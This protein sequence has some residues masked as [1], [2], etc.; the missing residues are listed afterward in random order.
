VGGADGFILVNLDSG[1]G[2]NDYWF[3]VTNTSAGA[4]NDTATVHFDPPGSTPPPVPTP[5]AVNPYAVDGYLPVGQYANRGGWGSI[6]FDGTNTLGYKPYSAYEA[7][8]KGIGGYDIDG[9][10]LGAGGGYV[11]YE[12]TGEGITNDPDNAYGVDFIVYGNAIPGPDNAEAG[13]VKV[14]T[15][16]AIWYELAGSRYYDD[17]TQRHVD[18]SYRPK[19]PT[20][21]EYSL[22]PSGSTPFHP[23]DTF[24]TTKPALTWWPDY[25]GYIQASGAYTLTEYA[26]AQVNNVTYPSTNSIVTYSDVALVTGSNDKS[27]FQFGYADV[28]VSGSDYGG[29]VNPYSITPMD[30]GGDGFDIS[31]AISGN[32][33]PVALDYVKYIRIYT[34]AALDPT[35]NTLFRLMEPGP[36]GSGEISTEVCGVFSTANEGSGATTTPSSVSFS[37]TTYNPTPVSATQG[38]TSI[39]QSYP[40]LTY[41]I[42]NT[43]SNTFVNG[44]PLSGSTI[45]VLLPTPGSVR[46]Y[47]II[48][49]DSDSNAYVNTVK[50]TRP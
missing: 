23:W 45:T 35:D 9:I 50:F 39:T 30:E 46:Y 15:N 3:E 10:S 48:T 47:Q 27:F 19:P 2:P 11:Q 41:T 5:G 21:V 20:S 25:N 49:Q 17:S 13:A 38:I 18:V 32:G 16:G 1:G 8:V 4:V 14:S 22:R 12:V 43:A 24:L 42:G 6:S 34:A 7:N 29:A 28:H 33:E 31:W 40:S 36:Y 26:T 44:K 37:S